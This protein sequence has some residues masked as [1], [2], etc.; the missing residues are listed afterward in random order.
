VRDE[1]DGVFRESAAMDRVRTYQW[2][3]EEIPD[4]DRAEVERQHLI[5]CIAAGALRD[6]V[7]G[8]AQLRRMNLLEPPGA[9]LDD[10]EAVEHAEHTREILAAKQPRS[11]GPNRGELVDAIAA[12]SPRAD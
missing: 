2:N 7:L 10:P 11:R 1:A 8:R 3:D 12:A 6:P 4:W 9:V 5:F